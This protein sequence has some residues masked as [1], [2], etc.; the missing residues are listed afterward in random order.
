MSSTRTAPSTRRPD[1]VAPEGA[2]TS[3]FRG[4]IQGLRALA[5]VAV[6]LDH[7]LAWPSG[8]FLGVDVFFVISGFI[9]T[10]LLLRQHD[11]RGRISFA[12]FYRKRVKRIL[13]AST[14]VLV[15]TIAA[16]WMVFLTGRAASVTWDGIAAFLFVANWR[17]AWTDTD[18][19]SAD[20]AVSPLQ[21]YWSLGVEEQF[22]VVWPI[23]LVLGLAVSLRLRG[24]GRYRGVLTAILLVV[25]VGSF[26]WAMADTAGNAAAAYFSTLSRAWELGVG[27]LL[28]VGAPLVRRIPDAARPVIAWAGLAVI[29]SGLAV[30]G[31]DSPIPAPGS[32]V[33]VVGAALVIAA[34]TGGRQ[35]LLWPLTNPVS[36]YLGDIS[37]SL[38]L[39][40]F[41]VIVIL[42]AVS[43]A[44]GLGYPVIVLVLTLGLAVLSFHGL[45]DP[46]RRS[47]W[48]EPGA[49]ARRRKRRARRRPGFGASTGTKV[50][51]LGTAALLT[52]TFVS[53]A[54]A[55]QQRIAEMTAL[56]RAAVASAED[57]EAP[58]DAAVPA[59]GE[60]GALQ[61]RIRDALT[62]TS[63][64]ALDPAIDG[65]EA[66]AVPVEDGLGC[67]RTDIGNPRSCSFGDV[68]KPTVMV[69]GDSTGITLL[70][71]VRALFEQTHHVRGLTFAGCAVMDVRWSFPDASTK[72]GC[73]EFRDEAV[74]A[75]RE[76]Q[77][78]ILFVSNSYGQV[79]QL[80]SKATGDDAVAEWSA[81]V[82]STVAEVRDSVGKV[83]LVSSPP[84][85]QPLETCATKVAAP[86]D[87]QARIPGAWKV[88]D[89]AQR[90]AAAALGIAY[91][92]T[93]ALFCWEERCPSFVG[94]T[95]TKRDSVHT[96]PTYAQEMTPA[97]RQVLDEALAAVP[98]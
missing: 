96:T 19:W 21:H 11:G 66:A 7:L 85:G 92:D 10:S 34:G 26:A 35:R 57:A 15:V 45:E 55:H 82:Q 16:S 22:Y 38:Y 76:A 52:V 64:P 75:I 74:A 50:A 13:P 17:F 72:S 12:D 98:S 56:D 27:A 6:I 30:L 60:L 18:Y 14:A 36:R 97:F 47:R 44:D 28:A 65:L 95:P 46:I 32:A 53:L 29:V 5:V 25:T 33:P 94:T 43:D 93:S 39:W 84:V 49:A 51:A 86:A 81:G 9:I 89:R 83:V 63:W 54:V 41:P 68:R 58:G 87:C 23:L 91:V 71:T 70:P 4:D 37:Y 77:P 90:D 67:G 79:L 59:D 31:S 2:P 24:P 42:A 62:A 69:L 3:A 80:A 40:H 88:G 61:G 48:L 8:G 73:L 78:E 20:S 1:A